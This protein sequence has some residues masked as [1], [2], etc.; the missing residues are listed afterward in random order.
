MQWMKW[1]CQSD[2]RLSA[3]D[4]KELAVGIMA[5]SVFGSWGVRS[6]DDLGMVF[7]PLVLGGRPPAC[8]M[9][10]YEWLEKSGPRS[11]NGMP[12]FTSYRVLTFDDSKR[13]HSMLQKLKEVKP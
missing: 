6:G 11:I 12:I 2:Y 4:I 3:E 9:H 5:G 8:A 13:V 7:M 1:W 10:I